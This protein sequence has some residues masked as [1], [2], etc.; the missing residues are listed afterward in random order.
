MPCRHCL[1]TSGRVT[2]NP[3]RHLELLAG[4]SHVGV[5]IA[6]CQRCGGVGLHYWVDI[7]DDCWLYWCYLCEA[8]SQALRVAAGAGEDDTGEPLAAVEARRLIQQRHV[9]CEHPVRGLSWINGSTALL[10]GAPW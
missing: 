2:D 8:E 4:D 9:L 5:H 1:G 6:V 3:F 10:D 7:Y